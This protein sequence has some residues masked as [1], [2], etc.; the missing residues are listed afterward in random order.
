[1]RI[2]AKTNS[3]LLSAK[4]TG[5][6]QMADPLAG[7]FRGLVMVEAKALAR[8]KKTEIAIYGRGQ[9]WKGRGL[10]RKPVF[11]GLG[12][13]LLTTVRPEKSLPSFREV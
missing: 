13:I 8:R 2:D 12:N 4:E 1:M 10:V 5:L 9:A 3:I 6:W 11:R 7:Q